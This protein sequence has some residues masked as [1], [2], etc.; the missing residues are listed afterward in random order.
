MYPPLLKGQS[1]PS[2][3]NCKSIVSTL[4]RNRKNF[5]APPVASVAHVVA[6]LAAACLASASVA[7]SVAAAGVVFYV[8]VFIRL[9]AFLLLRIA[10]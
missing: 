10:L 6:L 4:P 7:S 5:K 3:R 1:N 2:N 8:S 9:S